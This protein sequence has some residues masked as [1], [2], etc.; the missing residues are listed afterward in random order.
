MKGLRLALLLVLSVPAPAALS[1]LPDPNEVS[2]SVGFGNYQ[3]QLTV[4]RSFLVLADEINSRVT[5]IGQRVVEGA[6]L[7][8]AHFIFR[9][10]NS[11]TANAFATSGGFVY[12]TSGLLELVD[13][14][15]ELAAVLAHEVGHISQDHLID[16]V[17]RKRRADQL[18]AAGS[19]VLALALAAGGAYAG[20]Q[21]GQF[22]NTGALASAGLAIGGAVGMTIAEIT[23]TGYRVEDENEAD[24]LA[25]ETTIRAGYDPYAIIRMFR[26]LKAERQRSIREARE[27]ASALV[28]KKPGLDDRMKLVDR[29]IHQLKNEDP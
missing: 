11:P 7:D 26:K 23:L 6:G 1:E 18:V 21:T 8:P 17:Y 10:V 13:E 25:V 15:D 29:A 5:S 20:A 3:D 9:I 16:H 24:G 14:P 19:T 12:V 28:N 27:Y 2:E 4:S 22:V